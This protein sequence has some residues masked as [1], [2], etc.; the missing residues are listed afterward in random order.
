MKFNVAFSLVLLAG[1][2]AV[3]DDATVYPD[4]PAPGAAGAEVYGNSNFDD[5]D[6]YS[7][8]VPDIELTASEKRALALSQKVHAKTVPVTEGENGY[9]QYVYG[10]QKASVVCAPLRVCDLQ[11]QQGES[12]LSVFIGDSGRWQVEPATVGEGGVYATE[13][14]IIKPL[15]IDLRT[16]LV[17]TT[18]RRVYHIELVSTKK[19]AMSQISF[20]YPEDA[21]RKFLAKQRYENAVTER[22]T[23]P[24]TGEYLGNLDFAYKITGDKTDWYPVRVY[25]D[26]KKTIIEMP[27]S[28][29]S[30]ES[31][32]F[33]VTKFNQNS[34]DSEQL[35]NYRL[36]N[37]K[38]IIDAVFYEGVLIAGVGGSQDKV[39]ITREVGR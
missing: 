23:I 7:G 27:K 34:E 5:F 36:Q 38:Y 16:N 35:V 3:A 14:V 33:V 26:G 1:G 10:A 29:D 8:G 18:N 32:A 22:N 12:I 11:L 20:I 15:D 37:G 25:N 9:I 2:T 39:T 6:Y 30:N 21:Q 31:P 17:I 19:Q 24:E 13:H 4:D 28:M